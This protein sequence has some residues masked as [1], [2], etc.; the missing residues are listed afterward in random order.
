MKGKNGTPAATTS[1]LRYYHKSKRKVLS[2]P[3]KPQIETGSVLE[4]DGMLDIESENYKDKLNLMVGAVNDQLDYEKRPV[5]VTN[6]GRLKSISKIKQGDFITFFGGIIRNTESVES[7]E[8]VFHDT[9]LKRS[10]DVSRYFY[11]TD[12]GRWINTSPWAQ[13]KPNVVAYVDEENTNVVVVR[14]K[15][16]IEPLTELLVVGQ[17]ADDIESVIQIGDE[18]KLIRA[19]QDIAKYPVLELYR[20]RIT[21]ALNLL[22]KM[23]NFCSA[24]QAQDRFSTLNG[25]FC[26]IECK[27]TWYMFFKKK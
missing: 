5:R 25:R 20:G 10:W 1:K 12:V 17:A 3:D 16:D 6:D 9:G 23:C 24:K 22:Q 14:A 27:E 13:V 2:F 11:P 18:A 21:A 15:T 26:S 7:A 8:H 4:T 19:Q